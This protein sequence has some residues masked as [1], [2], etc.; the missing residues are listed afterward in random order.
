MFPCRS[1]FCGV[2]DK[3]FIEV[4]WFHKTFTSCPEKFLVVHLHLGIILLQNPQSSMY[5][6]VLNRFL[7]R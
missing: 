2:F 6:S 3:I 4:P 5:D 7:S 1:S